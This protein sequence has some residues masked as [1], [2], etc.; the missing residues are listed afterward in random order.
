M[1]ISSNVLKMLEGIC[2]PIGTIS[3]WHFSVCSE[4]QHFSNR[5]ACSTTHL[6]GASVLF[7]R[8]TQPVR[9][10]AC[11]I[12]AAFIETLITNHLSQLAEPGKCREIMVIHWAVSDH[13]NPVPRPFG[14]VSRWAVQAFPSSPHYEEG[15]AS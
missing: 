14:S 13:R 4:F 15:G 1:L 6:C 8:V 5:Q 12:L 10:R 2:L 9:S 7:L 3:K 11:V